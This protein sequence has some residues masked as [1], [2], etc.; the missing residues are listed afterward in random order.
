MSESFTLQMGSESSKTFTVLPDGRIGIEGTQWVHGQSLS[1]NGG[2][3]ST[4]HE[5][6]SSLDNFS[7]EPAD[8]Q[9]LTY[10]QYNA[11]D[12]IQCA[13]IRL[14]RSHG[15]DATMRGTAIDMIR[16]IAEVSTEP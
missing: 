10:D 16:R 13:A 3:I 7:C 9:G 14:G 12:K 15:F 8:I 2:D 11:R 1:K 4:Q 6:D 5:T